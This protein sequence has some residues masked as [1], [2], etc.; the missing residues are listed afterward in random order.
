MDAAAFEDSNRILHS[1]VVYFPDVGNYTVYFD[2]F[3]ANKI[4]AFVNKL[5][6]LESGDRSYLRRMTAREYTAKFVLMIPIIAVATV[7]EGYNW[8]V[9]E[10]NVWDIG[11]QCKVTSYDIRLCKCY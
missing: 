8:K 6:E 2:R 4:R 1:R 11:R 9:M 5:F 7:Y 10:V 3:F